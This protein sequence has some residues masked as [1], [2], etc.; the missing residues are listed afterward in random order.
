MIEACVKCGRRLEQHDKT[1]LGK[2]FRTC[3]L[4]REISR[5]ASQTC[6]IKQHQLTHGVPF[7]T[8]RPIINQF[9]AI[10]PPEPIIIDDKIFCNFT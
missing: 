9:T 2:T 4:C 8:Y 6:R 7:E 10:P 3:R 5:R 1:L